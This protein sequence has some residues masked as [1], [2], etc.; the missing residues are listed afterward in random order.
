MGTRNNTLN[1]KN[2]KSFNTNHNHPHSPR[3][4]FYLASVG[5]L[6]V[7]GI[8]TACGVSS[9]LA[10]VAAIALGGIPVIVDVQTTK[11]KEAEDTEIK[12]QLA[13]IRE[14]LKFLE[15]VQKQLTQGNK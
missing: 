5:G 10:G 15:S 2:N 12:K 7:V 6:V 13:E 8:L 9:V 4:V 11:E 3:T 1:Q 14:Q